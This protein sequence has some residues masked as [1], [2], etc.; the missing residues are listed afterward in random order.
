MTVHVL[1]DVMEIELQMAVRRNAHR[2]IMRR[3]GGEQRHDLSL[4]LLA[5]PGLALV[6][7]LPPL[8]LLGG[9]AALTTGTTRG[10]DL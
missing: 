4:G 1:H 6:R 8:G 9:L 5:D 3:V 2:R 10:F 7:L